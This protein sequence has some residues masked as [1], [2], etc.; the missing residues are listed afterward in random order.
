MVGIERFTLT[1]SRESVIDTLATL[2][3]EAYQDWQ[4]EIDRRCELTHDGTG[5]LG[6]YVN[7]AIAIHSEV[8]FA[9]GTVSTLLVV[10]EQLGVFD[11]VNNLVRE[12]VGDHVADDWGMPAHREVA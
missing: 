12:R 1:D 4:G 3:V 8:G 11:E 6:Q 10:A 9:A 7:Q 2:L 5:S